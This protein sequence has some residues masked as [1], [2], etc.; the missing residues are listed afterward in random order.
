M[1]SPGRDTWHAPQW[2]SPFGHLR[3]I[4]AAHPSPEL[5]AVYHVLHRRLTP[6]HSPYALVAFPCVTEKLSLSR[7]SSSCLR[8]HLVK[9]RVVRLWPDRTPV[10]SRRRRGS[11][12]LPH[13]SPS[14]NLSSQ[15][16]FV[17]ERCRSKNGL[18]N[19]NGWLTGL[20]TAHLRR[21]RPDI[22]P[23]RACDTFE[24]C[25]SVLFSS[26]EADPVPSIARPLVLFSES[27]GNY[28]AFRRA[29]QASDRIKALTPV[30]ALTTQS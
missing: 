10:G 6:R 27:V 17:K 12:S 23:G 1:C 7:F 28:T 29:C 8:M 3:L 2:V 24:G 18:L 15:L 11:S 19:K 9:C 26:G 16:H 4:T 30:G 22:L 25:L 5:F 20:R 21:K 14:A 13:P